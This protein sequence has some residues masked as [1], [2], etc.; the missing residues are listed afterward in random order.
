MLVIIAVIYTA[1]MF[2]SACSSW[3][4]KMLFLDNAAVTS[5]V[6]SKISLVSALSHHI[7]FQVLIPIVHLTNVF[8]EFVENNLTDDV[9]CLVL[10][11][12]LNKALH[13]QKRPKS[14]WIVL[15][16]HVTM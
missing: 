6:W 16:F 2:F 14:S 13:M 11:R 10:S 3:F 12:E 15:V 9:A 8:V 4:S 7:S 5:L 1:L